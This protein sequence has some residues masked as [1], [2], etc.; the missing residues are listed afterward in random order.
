MDVTGGRETGATVLLSERHREL[1]RS[2]VEDIARVNDPVVLGRIAIE[3][4][5][6]REDTR[7]VGERV[8]CG[9]NRLTKPAR[10]RRS[11]KSG[12]DV[13]EWDRNR[14]APVQHSSISRSKRAS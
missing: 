13:R 11:R 14:S 8:L 2:R 12:D 3:V 1:A 4:G 9:K 10:L 6:V 5:R 7:E